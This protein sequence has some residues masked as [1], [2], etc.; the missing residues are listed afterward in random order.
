[1]VVPER[2][3]KRIRLGIV[4]GTVVVRIFHN[5]QR[6]IL[7]PLPSFQGWSMQL[8]ELTQHSLLLS[9][10]TWKKARFNSGALNQ[11]AKYVNHRASLQIWHQHVVAERGKFT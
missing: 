4:Q 2:H 7:L 8:V 5:K 10:R 6:S 1:M 11:H 3:Q 9:I